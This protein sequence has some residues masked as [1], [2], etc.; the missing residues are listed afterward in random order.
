MLQYEHTSHSTAKC[1][2][3][4]II[5]IECYLGI[6][7]P[8]T[9]SIHFFL[10][11]KLSVMVALCNHLA[12]EA[13]TTFILLHFRIQNFIAV[14]ISLLNNYKSGDTFCLLRLTTHAIFFDILIV[15][16]HL[17]LFMWHNFR[18]QATEQTPASRT[19]PVESTNF[20]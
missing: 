7:M 19:K 4:E 12:F 6:K 13:M 17:S 5:S 16:I 3:L 11:L 8:L 2:S 9:V 1:L 10:I 20:G 18:I 14:V 15:L